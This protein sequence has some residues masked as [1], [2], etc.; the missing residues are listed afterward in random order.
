[1]NSIIFIFLLFKAVFFPKIHSKF[2]DK[3]NLNELNLPID[4]YAY[5]CFCFQITL[6][7]ADVPSTIRTNENGVF[8]ICGAELRP[9]AP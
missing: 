1:M 8:V 9:R 7:F 6:R 5:S 2:G 3:L 4:L